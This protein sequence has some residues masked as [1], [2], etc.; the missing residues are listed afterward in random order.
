MSGYASVIQSFL[1]APEEEAFFPDQINPSFLPLKCDLCDLLSST[2]VSSRVLLYLPDNFSLFLVSK[3][4]ALQLLN[5]SSYLLMTE[6]T[7]GPCF[8]SPFLKQI[9]KK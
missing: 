6:F 2:R 7:S 5:M 9:F 8:V 3:E 4:K 1:S